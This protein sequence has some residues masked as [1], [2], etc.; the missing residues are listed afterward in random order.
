MDG[1]G[2]GLSICKKLVGLLG[3]TDEIKITTEVGLGS[4]F[5]FIIYETLSDSNHG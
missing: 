4:A 1:V 3:P 5:S 2:L